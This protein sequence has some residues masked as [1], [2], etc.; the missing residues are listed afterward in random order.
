MRE[1]NFQ[2]EL[3]GW[4]AAFNAMSK[5]DFIDLDRVFVIGL[6]N[7]GGFSPLAARDHPVRGYISGFL[8][9]MCRRC[10][11][12]RQKSGRGRPNALIHPDLETSI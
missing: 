5:Y 11:E 9:L 7:G 10:Q 12:D 2:S 1:L 4:Q 3:T 8:W 6:S